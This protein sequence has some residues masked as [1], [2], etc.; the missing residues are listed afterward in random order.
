MLLSFR[1]DNLG[2]S[3]QQKVANTHFRMSNKS[4][5][6]REVKKKKPKR[7]ISLV[8]CAHKMFPRRL[9]EKIKKRYRRY[10]YWITDDKVKKQTNKKKVFLI[11]VAIERK[12]R[13]TFL[14]L[15]EEEKERKNRSPFAGRLHDVR[16]W[17]ERAVQ[18]I[19]AVGF[20]DGQQSFRPKSNHRFVPPPIDCADRISALHGRPCYPKNADDGIDPSSFFSFLWK[21]KTTFSFL[22]LPTENSC[23]TQ[24]QPQ[25]TFLAKK[26]AG[27][28]PRAK[29][30]LFVLEELSFCKTPLYLLLLLFYTSRVEKER[31]NFVWATTQHRSQRTDGQESTLARTKESL[32]HVRTKLTKNIQR[33]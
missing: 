9:A 1:V 19:R 31:T 26:V 15:L 27:P 28:S 23:G 33:E 20:G 8:S 16:I 14:L 12:K 4:P 6:N 5:H 30:F 21:K 29:H 32:T 11:W 10:Y 17:L 2:W 22:F 24:P 25:K 13:W 18:A 3:P 7:I